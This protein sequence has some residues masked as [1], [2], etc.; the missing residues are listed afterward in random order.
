MDSWHKYLGSHFTHSAQKAKL[1]VRPCP[2][3]SLHHCPGSADARA[4]G[5]LAPGSLR[6]DLL[7]ELTPSTAQAEDASFQQRQTLAPTI[8]TNLTEAMTP[9]WF[10]ERFFPLYI[11]LPVSMWSPS[12]FQLVIALVRLNGL[13]SEMTSFFSVLVLPKI[14][15][16]K[17][18][19][20]GLRLNL[21]S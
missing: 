1:S 17:H 9:P 11:L 2:G 6:L 5:P 16:Q 4:V 12:A 19:S 10:G 21:L 18:L 8:L 13:A 15:T 7:Q 20:Q 14:P 3:A